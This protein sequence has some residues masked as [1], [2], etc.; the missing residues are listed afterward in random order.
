MS[1]APT[2]N[3]QVI[4]QTERATLALLDAL[5]AETGTSFESWVTLN[6][7]GTDGDV[8]TDVLVDQLVA[9]LRIDEPT[10]RETVDEV[11]QAGLAGDGALVQLT[12]DGRAR[13]E[14]ISSGINQ[15]ARRLYG[16]LP[17]E[18]LATARRVLETV[19]DRARA[20]LA[21]R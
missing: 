8:P 10:A 6:L 15:I 4:G 11:R 19:A 17:Q 5:L 12:A 13:Y 14:H 18:D 16:D 20:E 3:G 21:S 7:L 9:G 2:L 1:E